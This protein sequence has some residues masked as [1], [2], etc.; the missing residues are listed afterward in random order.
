VDAKYKFMTVDIGAHGRQ[1]DSGVFTESSV[2]RHL[3]A[4]SFNL[5]PPRQIPRTNIT[6]PYVFVGDQRYP[7]KEYLMRPY[8]TDNGRVSRQK[9][10]FNYRLNRARRTV[11]C[12]L[13]ILVAKWRCLKT[14]SQVNP[15][16]VDNVT[17]TVC[18]LHNITGKEGVNETVAMTQITPESTVMLEAQGATTVLNK[19]HVVYETGSCNILMLKG[20][21]IFTNKNRAYIIQTK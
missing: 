15:E 6:L 11:E 4:G 5:P 2:F 17:R 19:M 9:E 21:M 12:A 20:Q 8:P 7:L 18:L 3:E 16:H 14:E 10:I 1:S 13:G